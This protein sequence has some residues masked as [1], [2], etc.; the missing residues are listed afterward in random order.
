MSDTK[1]QLEKKLA[2]IKEKERQQTAAAEE[3][4]QTKVKTDRSIKLNDAV[5]KLTFNNY[6]R[7]QLDPEKVCK[8]LN[9]KATFVLCGWSGNVERVITNRII[10]F[11]SPSE[12]FCPRDKGRPSHVLCDE[13]GNAVCSFCI[14]KDDMELAIY[15]T[16]EIHA[17]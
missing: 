7:E 12:V 14:Y 13:N 16:S 2:T 11:K 15:P 17:W 1:A 4:W 3:K 5:Y 6:D 10:N 9:D 8:L